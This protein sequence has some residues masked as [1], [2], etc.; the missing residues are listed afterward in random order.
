MI[1]LA[2]CPPLVD[3]TTEFHGC[4]TSI[5]SPPSP[6]GW[7]RCPECG[8]IFREGTHVHTRETAGA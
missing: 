7:F 8:L 4:G 6:E 1:V 3:F 5:F 2:T